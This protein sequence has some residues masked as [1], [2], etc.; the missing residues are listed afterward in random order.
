MNWERL[1]SE[2]RVEARAASKAELDELRAKIERKLSN[3]GLAREA[4]LTADECFSI[5]YDAARLVAVL[6]VRAAG[7]RILQVGAHYSTFLALGAAMGA[8]VKET[9]I[10]LDACRQ[11]RNAE[12]YGRGRGDVTV[13]DA[14]ELLAEAEKLRERVEAWIAAE[15][16]GLA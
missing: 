3:A 10:Y 2:R 9:V 5:A 1:Q 11:R 14:S 12:E 16:N 7:Y 15:H 4:G 8:S 6:A 13:R